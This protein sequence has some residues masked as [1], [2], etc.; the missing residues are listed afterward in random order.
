M[1][2][3]LESALSA[4]LRD[5]V[6]AKRWRQRRSVEPRVAINPTAVWANGRECINFCSNDYLGLS[7]HPQI[8]AAFIEAAKRYGTG[9]GASHLVTGHGPEHEALEN[10]LAQFTGRPRALV[11]STGYMANL[12][13]ASAIVRR[14][15]QIFEDRLNHAS[16]LDAGRL[17]GARFHRYAHASPQDL[18]QQLIA[19][20][21]A[22]GQR[23]VVVTDGIFSMDGDVAPLKELVAVCSQQ[24]AWLMV[25][26]AHG[27]GALG[28]T[29]RG[30]LELSG[31]Q[32]L[33]IPIYMATLGKALGTF[34]AFIAGSAVLIDFLINRARTYIYTTALPP[35]VAA[36][37]RAALRVLQL[38]PWRRER[39]NDHINRFTSGAAQLGLNLMP[40][41]SAIQPLILGTED[42]TLAASALLL[43]AGFLV[44]A[45][46]PPTV[47][48]GTSRLR[49]TLSAAH[50]T[51]DIDRLLDALA[52][53]PVG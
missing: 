43:D 23:R 11:F 3:S 39:L 17:S 47:P 38:E 44:T 50:D 22:D 51:A 41:H 33:E 29:G 1:V 14:D 42:G 45:I 32:T 4:E 52:A 37:S 25:D 40:S 31:D 16:L 7:A 12:S 19:A 46:R 9:A 15:D 28:Q 13:I 27:F 20:P 18:L 6:A 34:G 53:L 10:E 35:A 2:G 30:S 48:V 8:T 24:D 49:I 36:A 21:A 5:I 26:D